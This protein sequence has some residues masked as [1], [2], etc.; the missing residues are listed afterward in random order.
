MSKEEEIIRIS[1]KALPA[2]P[3]SG[4][5]GHEVQTIRKSIAA[6]GNVVLSGNVP[7]LTW[8]Q[9]VNPNS[10]GPVVISAGAGAETWGNWV[11]VVTPPQKF[12]IVKIEVLLKQK[13]QFY[14][15]CGRSGQG[16]TDISHLSV[17]DSGSVVIDTLNPPHRYGSGDDLSVR[18]KSQ[19]G[20]G[21]G[22]DVWIFVRTPS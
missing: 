15:E 19:Q 17:Q 6:S 3:V 22:A 11:N 10:G 8:R 18:A 16:D 14:L 21:I 4:S 2:T 5:V 7:V 9:S 12:E 1:T 13:D 20:S